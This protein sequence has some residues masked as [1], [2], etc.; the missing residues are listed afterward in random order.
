MIFQCYEC[1]TGLGESPCDDQHSGALVKCPQ[2]ENIACLIRRT[3]NEDADLILYSRACTSKEP[4]PC[5]DYQGQGNLV[6]V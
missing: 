6:H 4:E 3:Q 1:Q 2:D 5:M